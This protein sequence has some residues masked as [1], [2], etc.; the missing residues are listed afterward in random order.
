M[1][2]AYGDSTYS[3]ELLVNTSPYIGP[4]SP[5]ARVQPGGRERATLL[6]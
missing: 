4:G 5:R 3:E 2:T 1:Q 6:R